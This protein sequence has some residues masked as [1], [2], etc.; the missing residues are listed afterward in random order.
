MFQDRAVLNIRFVFASE[1]NSGPSSYLVFSWIVPV[2]PKLIRIVVTWHL[3]QHTLWR[4]DWSNFLINIIY[5]LAAARHC[6][7]SGLQ[8]HSL[9]IGCVYSEWTDD[10]TLSLG[11][12]L[13]WLPPGD[14]YWWTEVIILCVWWGF[15]NW[16][17][18]LRAEQLNCYSNLLAIFTL[19][20]L[21]S[22]MM[23]K[24]NSILNFLKFCD[25]ETNATCHLC[26]A[27][28]SHGSSYI[29]S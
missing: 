9:C 1:P 8:Y 23:N 4:V 21:V 12:Y 24:R 3:F 10:A 27:V 5:A 26:N 16:M 29:F 2:G 20:Q 11:Q 28:I 7:Q 6:L 25:D 14:A 19:L 17:Q 18:D 22:P 15:S 13:P